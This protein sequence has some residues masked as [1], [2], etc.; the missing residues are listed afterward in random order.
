MYTT[1]SGIRH[2]NCSAGEFKAARCDPD[3]ATITF[4][5]QDRWARVPRV[6]A[7]DKPISFG[8]IASD[9]DED[10]CWRFFVF[11]CAFTVTVGIIQELSENVLEKEVS[12]T[13]SRPKNAAYRFFADS[14]CTLSAVN[15]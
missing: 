5:S 2:N 11:K 9:N 10:C 7:A 8:I 1:F 3:V 12:P 13:K 15:F 6:T 4:R 14:C